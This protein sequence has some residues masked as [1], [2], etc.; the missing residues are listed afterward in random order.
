MAEPYELTAY[1]AARRIRQRELSPVTLVESLLQR[2]D[3]LEPKVQAWVTLDRAGALAAARQLEQEI[4]GGSPRGPLHGV[5]VGV[6]DIYFTAGLTTTGGS[7]IYPDF[8]PSY[9]ATAVARLKQAGAIILGKTVTTEFATADPGPTRNPWNLE[10]TPGGSSS[11]SAAGVA[12][13]MVPIAVGSQTG[14][15]IQRPAAYCG[16]CGLKPTYGRVSR[17]GV[18]PVSW[19]LDHIGP[20]ARTVTD[21]ALVLQVLAGHDPHDPASSHAPVPDYL[22]AVQQADRPPR[23]GLV[24]Q[25]YLERADS[26]LRAHVEGVA[27]QLARAGA[28]VEEVKLPESFRAVLAAHRIVMHVEAAAVHA[29]LFRTHADMYRPKLRA[30]LETGSL[31]P[32][33]AY[34]QAQR[35]RRQFRHDMAQLFQRVDFLLMPAAPG[36]APRD[37]TT[38]GDPSFNSPSS[39]AGVPAITVPSGLNAAG[40]PL[41]IQLQGPAFAEERLL[42]AARWC[43]ATLNVT[44]M[45]PLEERTER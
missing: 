41:A 26:E 38:T 28:A 5:P 25:F 23:L 31:I 24:R 22:Q 44:L 10:H 14:G 17:Y 1:D 29:E 20:L 40:L 35:V 27:D 42:G 6:K 34:M 15:S 2:I 21:I 16:V 33:V 4:Q 19:C 18:F 11:G 9:D 39:F 7:R 36:P 45:P 12:A 8:V 30:T 3:Q 37:L 13:R 43:E 32:G